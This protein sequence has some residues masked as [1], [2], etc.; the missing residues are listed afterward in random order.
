VVMHPLWVQAVPGSFPGSGKG[1]MFHFFCFVVVVFLLFLS[2]RHYLPQN[3]AI[4]FT[5]LFFF[6]ILNILQDL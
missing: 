2:K 6:S 3:F 4:P 1:F 5:M